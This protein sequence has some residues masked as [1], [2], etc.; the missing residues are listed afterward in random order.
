[1]DDGKPIKASEAVKSKD[2]GF[3]KKSRLSQI[4]W[5]ITTDWF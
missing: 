3:I 5:L 2:V 4:H 1:M